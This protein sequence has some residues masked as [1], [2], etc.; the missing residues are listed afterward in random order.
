MSV[1]SDQITKAFPGKITLV[2]ETKV[3][4]NGEPAKRVTV[5]LSDGRYV[6]GTFT[7]HPRASFG[8]VQFHGHKDIGG[9]MIAKIRDVLAGKA[10]LE[11][12]GCH[13]D[14]HEVGAHRPGFTPAPSSTEREAPTE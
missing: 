6:A 5:M 11:N 1:I 12:D 13:P 14:W 8:G 10:E 2:S 4:Q 3:E 7:T 9:L